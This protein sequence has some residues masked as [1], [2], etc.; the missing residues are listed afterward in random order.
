MIFTLKKKNLESIKSL[1]Q[2]AQA[3]PVMETFSDLRF[4]NLQGPILLEDSE[5]QEY[6]SF[7]C[8]V[9]DAAVKS[10]IWLYMLP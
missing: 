6:H 10:T 1:S 9:T 4:R 8:L 3:F 5:P 7:N 2:N